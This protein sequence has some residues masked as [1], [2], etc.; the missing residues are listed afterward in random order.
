MSWFG[1][2]AFISKN[3]FSFIYLFIYIIYTEI[4]VQHS[5]FKWRSVQNNMNKF[6]K[7]SFKKFIKVQV[8]TSMPW[9]VAKRI[10]PWTID[11]NDWLSAAHQPGLLNVIADSV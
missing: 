4:P 3:Y 7:K 9:V 2:I 1:T 10:W 6:R 8:P 11:R 5:W